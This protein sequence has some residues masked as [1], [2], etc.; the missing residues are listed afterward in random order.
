MPIIASAGVG[1]VG[2]Y[3]PKTKAYDH[4]MAKACIYSGSFATIGGEQICEDLWQVLF[5]SLILGGFFLVFKSSFRG[6]GGKLGS[7]AFCAVVFFLILKG[8]A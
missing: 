1:Y 7:L 2:S 8:G 4:E 3:L 5:L 6:F